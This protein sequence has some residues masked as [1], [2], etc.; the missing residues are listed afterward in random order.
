MRLFLLS[1]Y[2]KRPPLLIEQHI[3]EKSTKAR[4]RATSFHGLRP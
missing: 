3:K 4:A 1:T 2:K